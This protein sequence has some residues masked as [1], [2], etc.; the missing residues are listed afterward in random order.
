MRSARAQCDDAGCLCS[1][2]R[3]IRDLPLNR[4]PNSSIVASPLELSASVPV[5]LLL[6]PMNSAV[7]GVAGSL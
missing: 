4:S 5:S 1:G 6:A 2:G 3:F 7:K